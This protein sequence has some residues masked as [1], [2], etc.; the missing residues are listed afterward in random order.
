LFNSAAS[1]IRDLGRHPL[2]DDVL[3]DNPDFK[4]EMDLLD[5]EELA[6]ERDLKRCRRSVVSVPSTSGAPAQF[7]TPQLQTAL[8]DQERRPNPMHQLRGA[9][10]R[11]ADAAWIRDPECLLFKEWARQDLFSEEALRI[12]AFCPAF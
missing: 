5:H 6:Y 4:P 12:S 3:G 1:V 8:L 9:T 7:L 11:Q 2:F 10:F